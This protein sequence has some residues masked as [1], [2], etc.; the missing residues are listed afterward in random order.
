MTESLLNTREV[1]D[2]LAK[3]SGLTN[4]AGNP[5]LKHIIHRVVSDMFRT[6]E[7]FDVQPDEFWS[8]VSYITALGQ[9]NEAG[10][11]VPGLG[12]ETFLDL[13][14]DE[15]ERKVG[16]EG[17]TPRT[18]EGPLY[19]AGA[20]L[21]KGEAR[22]DDG[23]EQGEVLFMDG[24]VRDMDGNPVAGAIVDVWHANTL[25]GYSFFDPSQS[26]S[27]FAAVSK[28]MPKGATASVS[29][30]P[31]GYACPPDGQTQKLLDQ[32]GRHGNRPAHIHFFVSAPDYR[33]LTTQINIDGD[34][35]LHD[36]FAFATRD[37]LIP[38]VRRST[39][40]AA[41]SCP[42]PERAVRADHL[43]FRSASRELLRAKHRRDT[44]A[45]RSC[46]TIRGRP[47]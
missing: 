17:G 38:E 15:A 29:L 2:L 32:L 3:V 28:P 37:G 31:S 41:N 6:I 43:R 19:I 44:A 21:S 5:R 42:R 11:L 4:D 20:P 1:K 9:A 26:S 39:D 34:A 10:L 7:D 30:L 14:M 22:L 16:I 24:Q 18:I 46:L 8:A 12:I 36:D 40:P 45:R 13:R 23:S 35:Y 47:L 27:I 25:G 33:K